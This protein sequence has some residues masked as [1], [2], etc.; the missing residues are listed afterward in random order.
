MTDSDAY[1]PTSKAVKDFVEGKGYTTNTGTV[2][3]VGVSVPTGLS[4]NGT[5]I[6]ESGTI[7]ISMG[8]GYAIPKDAS[9]D[10][11]QTAYTNS[12][13][14]SNADIL[15]GITDTSVEDWTR[16]TSYNDGTISQLQAGTNEEVRV[17]DASTIHNYV[18]GLGYTSN[19]GT[20][21]S[22]GLTMPTGFEVSDSPVTVD[23]SIAV[24]MAV[25]YAIPL[26]A[27]L[28]NFETAYVQSHTHSNA[29]ILN[30][31]TDASIAS[32]E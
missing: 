27:S 4:V 2:T 10:N 24:T 11:F 18:E 32:W 19:V 29:D 15:D 31:I 1:L 14:H 30:G 23:G 28:D 7:E 3:S 12:H 17:W 9:L 25:G 26:N 13:T 21:T 16:D 8:T 20:V 22:V 6:T 5:P